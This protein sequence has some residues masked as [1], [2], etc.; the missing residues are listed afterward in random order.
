MATNDSLM[1]WATTTVTVIGLVYITA[2][3][4]FVGL[5]ILGLGI[6]PFVGILIATGIVF[7][8]FTIQYYREYE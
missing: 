1:K 3:V 6:D 2:F 4:F 5:S 7:G 8:V